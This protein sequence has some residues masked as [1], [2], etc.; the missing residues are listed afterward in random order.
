M[1]SFC[2]ITQGNRPDKLNALIQ[3]VK[4]RGEIT[5]VVDAL[6]EGFLG[7]LRNR[8]C[9]ASNGDILVVCDDDIVFDDGFCDAVLGFGEF[10]V[11]CARLLNPDGSRY[12]DWREYPNKML[13]YNVTDTGNIC[14]PGALVVLKR[15]VFENVQWD[16]TIGFYQPPYEDVDFAARLHAAGYSCKM[17]VNAKALHDDDRYYQ[18][19]D[20]VVMR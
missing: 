7:A 15:E 6:D 11:M 19:G 16:E 1:V 12:W 9:K 18:D 3:S 20:V 2:V 10:D 13:D 5:I 14:P 4:G 17:N 8:A